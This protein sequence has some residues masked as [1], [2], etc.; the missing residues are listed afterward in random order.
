MKSNICTLSC[1]TFSG[2]ALFTG[3]LAIAQYDAPVSNSVTTV[4]TNTAVTTDTAITTVTPVTTVTTVTPN[5]PVTTV[6]SVTTNIPVTTVTTN[7][8]LASDPTV[9]P[10]APVASVTRNAALTSQTSDSSFISSE[11]TVNEFGQNKMA[12]KPST[13]DDP[14][15]YSYT[16]T[17]TY[18]DENGNTISR[19]VV[20]TGRPVTV[21]YTKDGD[22]RI[23]HKIVV[24]VHQ[25]E[26]KVDR[27]LHRIFNRD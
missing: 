17:T 13:S 11:G 27:L 10:N 25:G 5:T 19:D 9:T 20:T 16:K 4:T 6:T 23:I 21:Y 2:L 24:K 8:T 26:R 15:R 22:E 14:V 3:N 7:S 1:V 18:V 12:L